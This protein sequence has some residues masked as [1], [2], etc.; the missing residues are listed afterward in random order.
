MNHQLFNYQLA[1]EALLPMEV[2]VRSLRRYA[3]KRT[4]I[5]RRLKVV[6]MG[7]RTVGIRPADLEVWKARCAG[8]NV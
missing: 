4:P 7:H 8:E 6:R 5:N 2:S 3:S 1:A